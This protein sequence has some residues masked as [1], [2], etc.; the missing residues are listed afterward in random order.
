MPPQLQSISAEV[1]LACVRRITQL[2]FAGT[3]EG[4][5]EW[6]ALGGERNLRAL[7]DREAIVASLLRIPM[8]MYIGGRSVP[9]LGVAAVGVAPE[10]RGQGYAKRMM[11]AF[12]QDAAA[13]GWPLAGLYASTHTLYR[14]VGF[15]HATHR[16]QYTI[17]LREID[18]GND[19]GP[20]HAITEADEPAVRACYAR[21]ASMF[22]GML[23]RGPYIWSRTRKLRDAEYRGYAVRAEG[24]EGFDGYVYLNQARRPDGRQDITLSDLVFTTPAAGQRLLGLLADFGMM[25]EDLVFFGGPTHPALTLLKQQRYDVKLKDSS[26]IRVLNVQTA[27]ESR[28]YPA[29]L[30]ASASFDIAD[31]IVPANAGRWTLSVDR[32]VPTVTRD[33]DGRIRATARGLATLL[34]GYY[35]PRQAALVGEVAGTDADLA[36][37]GAIFAGGTPFM[38]EIY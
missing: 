10:N 32:G 22:D 19:R 2:A 8:G 35:T 1:D 17:S 5:K 28:G 21:F 27:L 13:E 31:D 15:E 12:V 24:K 34:T 16:F 26:L 7:R 18:A 20:L 3:A 37:A 11:R 4:V 29:G 25:G 23:D 14:S 38:T 36:A 9:L 30:T 6:M 33:G